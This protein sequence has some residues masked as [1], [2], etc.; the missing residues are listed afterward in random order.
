MAFVY[1]KLTQEE[2]DYIASFKIRA[3]LGGGRASVPSRASVDE[4]REMYYFPFQG[5]GY[6][7]G[8]D[9]A[10]PNWCSFIC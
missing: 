8:Y 4:E 6:R 9:D 5:Q 10:P 1:R 2:R 7:N 3:V